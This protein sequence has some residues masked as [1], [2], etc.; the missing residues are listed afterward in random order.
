MDYGTING[1]WDRTGYRDMGQE[2][3]V[4]ET[5]NGVMVVG[6]WDGD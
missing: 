3:A 6:V 5:V 2:K 4:Y 1:I